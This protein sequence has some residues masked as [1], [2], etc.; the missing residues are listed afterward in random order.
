MS[1]V[2]R[3]LSLG[4]VMMMIMSITN[5]ADADIS[6]TLLENI[7][8]INKEGPYLGI[9]VPKLKFLL[10]FSNFLPH[11]TIPQLDY[12]GRRFRVGTMENR[13]VIA[14][15][16]GNSML[17]SG[18]ATQLLLNLFK[19]EGVLH[20]GVA[21]N[22]NPEIQIGDVTIPHYWAHTG[23]WNWQR[24]G[25]GPD[26]ELAFESNGDY[27]RKYGYLKFS[28][29]EVGVLNGKN[30]DNLLNNVWYQPEEI[31][32]TEG[33][34]ENRQ[35]IFWVPINKHYYSLAKKLED[36]VLERCVNS[37]T[38]LPQTPKVVR[39]RSGVSANMLV[40]NA[41]Y[42]DF[43]H[44]KFK[45]TPIDMESAAVALVCRQQKT[46]FIV[47]RAIS[48][49]ASGS[50]SIE[51]STFSSLAT[52]NAVKVARKFIALSLEEMLTL[53]AAQ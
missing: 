38:C 10:Q 2:V 12:A 8:E 46:P 19:I 29:Y 1:M 41:A 49:L 39:V 5:V 14:V 6:S 23:L 32:S 51:S 45:A 35:H 30:S 34:P 4:W 21:G 37:T 50:S 28:D 15:V 3:I 16:T 7:D 24:F 11:A 33:E 40:D 13:K 26:D 18:L 48:D 25:D 22:A 9:V 52:Q 20:Y 47:I 17:N 27:T 42:R 43:L 44:T 36:I 31:Y 53:D